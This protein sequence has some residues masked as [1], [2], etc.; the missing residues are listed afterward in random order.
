LAAALVAESG[1]VTILVG[2]G[3]PAPVVV[4][5]SADVAFDAGAWM[6]QATQAL[7]GRGGGRPEQAQGGLTA[8]VDQILTFARETVG[9]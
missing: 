4:A 7:G 5:R 8:S 9:E 6:K 1:F 2:D 3:Q